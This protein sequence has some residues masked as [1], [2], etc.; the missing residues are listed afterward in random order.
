MN[1]IIRSLEKSSF[2]RFSYRNAKID[3][4]VSCIFC[5]IEGGIKEESSRMKI[6][7]WMAI[8]IITSQFST[9]LPVSAAASVL[10][11]E[12]TAGQNTSESTVPGVN[13]PTMGLVPE[14]AATVPGENGEVVPGESTP[15]P[16]QPTPEPLPEPEPTPTPEPT[17]EPEEPTPNPEPN[18]EPEPTPEP[19]P[20]PE[21]PAPN[22][23]PNPEPETTPNPEPESTPSQ[24]SPDI[25]EV[26]NVPELTV[27]PPQEDEPA[28]FE[29][30]PVKETWDFIMEIGEDARKVGQEEDLYASV[31]IAQAILESGSG[32]SRLSQ[33]PFYNLFGIK[34]L[35]EGN[36]ISFQTQEDDG[37]GNLYTV[38]ATFR[39]YD[40]IESSL[41][42]YAKL[43]K[44][45]LDHNPNFYKG[46]W[47]SE[48]ESYEDA[49]EYLTG[50]YASDTQ[51]NEKLNALIEAYALT[52]YDKEKPELPTGSEKMI[53]PV[54][55]PV[56]SS[57]F[58]PRG[59]GF[60]RGVDFAAPQGTPIMAS[61]SGTVIRSEYHSSWG[62]YVAIEHKDGLTTLYAHNHRNLVEVGQ[63][64]E[65]GEVIASMGSTGNSTGPHLHF[66]VSLSPSLARHQL[67][68]PLEVLSK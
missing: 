18:P 3:Y 49:T 50:R 66:E 35:Y 28:K 65:Q 25:K 42:D 68:D 46:V 16:E 56:V 23:E 34:G 7:K 53:Y 8:A 9:M 29:V 2:S 37:S 1:W 62:N 47:K 5:M 4:K 27:T 57:V 38:H 10:T 11:N 31:M 30:T 32:R 22:P 59:N 48:T 51:Y 12:S 54:S 33:E 40:S 41:K 20:E 55:N 61:L 24:P 21:E 15:A 60:H 26:P 44:E 13:G 67:I 63:T 45:G 58:G 52:S 17:P 43:L 39:Q 6:K 36:G 64:V 19:A 14:D